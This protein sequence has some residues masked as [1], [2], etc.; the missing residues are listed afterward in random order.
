MVNM[1]ELQRCNDKEQWDEYI[2]GNGGHPLQIW[3][4][5]QVK[6]G[7]GW[8]AERVFA[9]HEGKIVGAAQILVRRLPSPMKAFAYIPR[10][11]IC[12]ES[13]HDEFL[14]KLGVLVK[15][16]HK[17][18]TLSVEPDVVDFKKP[19]GWITATNKIL[20]AETILLDVSKT[21]A[22][23]LGDMAK[24]TRQYI[25]KS[26]AD[27]TIKQVK[28]DDELE[29]CLSLYRETAAR[30]GFNIHDDRYYYDVLNQLRDHSPIFMAYE[31]ETPV[32]FLWLAI[33][34]N[35]A[36]ELYGGV[37]DRGQALRANYALKWHAIRRVKEWGLTRYDFGGMVA[38]GVSNFK[39]GWS[40]EVTTF[41]GT[42]D[43][44]LS[45]LYPLWS[46]GLPFAK[47]TAQKLRRRK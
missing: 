20:P 30:A 26:A 15:R 21:E 7:H 24:K 6:A 41:A 39:Q 37:N 14:E 11:P 3:A 47:K 19:A 27:V 35:T 33:S 28:T 36:Y 9:Y 34:A 22:E 29:A 5:G 10:G 18:I 46:K 4:W 16:D 38:G 25:R 45:P 40:K 1:I 32:A 13:F 2:L 31:G 8:V 23:L 44:P 17:A 43:L 42:Y 12:E